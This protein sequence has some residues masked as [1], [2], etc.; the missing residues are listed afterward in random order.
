[1]VIINDVLFSQLKQDLDLGRLATVYYSADKNA[2]GY[3]LTGYITG[4]CKII[5]TLNS[6]SGT[7]QELK[8][9]IIDEY[10]KKVN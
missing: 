5:K 2:F 9:M 7:E 1:M 10:K 3:T 6:F 8:K 4:N